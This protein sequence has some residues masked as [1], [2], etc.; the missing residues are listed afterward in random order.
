MTRLWGL[1]VIVACLGGCEPAPNARASDAGGTDAPAATPEVTRTSRLRAADAI[2]SGWVANGWISGAVLHV[3]AEGERFQRA[4]GFA[5]E[6]GYA[7]GEYRPS[8]GTA[9]PA[10]ALEPIASPRGMTAGTLFDLASVTKVLGTTLALMLL[11]ERGQVDIQAPV[12]RYLSD[13]AS[14]DPAKRAISVEHL[15]THTSGLAQWQPTYYHADSADEAYLWIR[16]LPLQWGVGEGR[17]YSDLGFMLLGRVVEG[18]TGTGL[19]HFLTRELYGPLGLA[20]TGFNPQQWAGWKGEVAATSH[21]NPFEY[22]MVHDST[23]GYRYAGTATSWSGWRQR[24]LVG[25]VNDGNAYHA[26]GGV[27]GHAGLFSTAAD[28]AVLMQGLSGSN[29]AFDAL[30]SRRTVERFLAP[31]IEGQALGWQVPDFAP[32]GSYFHTGFTGTLVMG[33]PVRELDLVLLTNRQHK[34]VDEDTRYV[35]VEPLRRAVV[36]ALLDP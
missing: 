33:I 21:G 2:V 28:L 25:E 36:K 4:Y 22:R 5:E 26:F 19:E 10:D 3:E 16:R 20:D 34:G 15:L 9:L 29:P 27:A 17:H 23:F 14:E 11:V 13:F 30:V 35:D 7:A 18:V 12:T 8:G 32:E 1:G 31:R 24:T 6:F